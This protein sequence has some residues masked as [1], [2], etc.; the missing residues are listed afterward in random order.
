MA[1]PNQ[2]L[3][4]AQAMAQKMY[5]E[6][7]QDVRLFDAQFFQDAAMIVLNQEFNFGPKRQEQFCRAF[8][9]IVNWMSD[10]IL[11]DAKEDTD[12][13]YSKAKIDE[14]LK[15]ALGEYFVDYDTRYSGLKQPVR[16]V[17]DK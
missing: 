13:I 4:M 9:K 17:K 11:K 10:L 6:S 2:L 7:V 16:V 12:I 5:N 14:L 1:K 3:V 8:I 15:L